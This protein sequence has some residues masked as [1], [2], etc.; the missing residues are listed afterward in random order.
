ML[1]C[2]FRACVCVQRLQIKYTNEL[3]QNLRGSYIRF[4]ECYIDKT[5]CYGA[6]NFMAYAWSAILSIE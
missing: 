3:L 5:T 4:T 6:S 1:A 2:S